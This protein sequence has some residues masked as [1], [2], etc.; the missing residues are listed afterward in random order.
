MTQTTTFFADQQQ[1][2][3]RCI[4]K[5]RVVVDALL[6]LNITPKHFRAILMPSLHGPEFRWLRERGV[7]ARNLFLIERDPTIWREFKTAI[8]FVGCSTTPKPMAAYQAVDHAPLEPHDLVYLDY[9]N[10]PDYCHLRTLV[11][12]FRLDL[13]DRRTRLLVT[14]GKNRV[15]SDNFGTIINPRLRADAPGQAYVEAALT[16]SRAHLTIRKI[17]N[18]RYVTSMGIHPAN[19]VTTEVAFR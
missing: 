1:R 4:D 10:Q 15:G 18:H 19:F 13:I 11:K 8:R 6:K 14:F 17:V 12:L 3:L 9:F 5:D 16:T 7:P 2:D